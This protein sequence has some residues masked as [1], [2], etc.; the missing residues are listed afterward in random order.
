MIKVRSLTTAL[1]L[2]NGIAGAFGASSVYAADNYPT[3]LIRVI[4]PFAPG[5]SIY[6]LR[7][8]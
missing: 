1:A 2:A 5:G 4:V 7:A 8:W 3:R 6:T